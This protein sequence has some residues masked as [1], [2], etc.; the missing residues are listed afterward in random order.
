LSQANFR[1]IKPEI[2]V[3]GIDD[4]SH[5]PR[6]KNYIPLIGVVFRGGLSIEGVMSTRI[7][8]DGFDSTQAISDMITASPYFKQLRLIMLNGV[9]F[10]GFNIVDLKALHM[11]TGLPLIAVA[12]KKPDLT[13]VQQAIKKLSQHEERLKTLGNAGEIV[14]ITLKN[15]K[16]FLYCHI[17]GIKLEDAKT[18][19]DLTSTRSIT[20]EPLRVAHMIASG[21]GGCKI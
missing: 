18:I 6:S 3:L 14:P 4:A 8:V 1:A 7:L 21:I 9:T 17:L 15:K 10:G 16:G 19:L 5:I 13:S 12:Q 2:R 20:P 11:A